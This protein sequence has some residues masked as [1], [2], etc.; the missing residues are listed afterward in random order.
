VWLDWHRQ[1]HP[2]NGGDIA[3]LE[4]DQRR[5]LGYIRAMGRRRKGIKLEEYCW[6]DNL[7]SLPAEEYKRL[8][9]LRDSRE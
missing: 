1:A 9:F 8:P 4:A 3:T 5:Y 7:R 2:H 6:P